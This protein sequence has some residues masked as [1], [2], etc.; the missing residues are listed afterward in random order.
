MTSLLSALVL[1]PSPD[2]ASAADQLYARIQADYWSERSGLYREAWNTDRSEKSAA[3]NW[4]V[5]VTLSALNARAKHDA[6]AR[7]VLRRYVDS[8]EKYW[9]KRGP[10]PGFDVVPNPGGV[11]RYYDDNAWMVL[12]LAEASEIL[13]DPK[14]LDRAAA[15]LDYALSGED[16]KLGGGIYWRESDKASKNTCSNAPTAYACLLMSRKYGLNRYE[17][18]GLR[19]LKWTLANLMDPQDNLMWDSKSIKTGRVGRDKWTYNAA[20]TVAALAEAERRGIKSPVSARTMFDAA[21]SRWRKTGG[22]M[23]NPGRFS[24]LLAETGLREGYLSRSDAEAL[25]REVIGLGIDDRYP[26]N[27]HRRPETAAARYELIDQAAVLRW[28]ELVR[29]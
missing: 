5:G 16:E 9:N 7:K 28:L 3:F 12:A 13:D 19:I 8:T 10:V 25:A 22:G 2:I 17:E 18:P 15:A 23:D 26:D 27:W 6:G 21:W 4:S 29:G 20:L 24:H 14:Q 1:M 11:D